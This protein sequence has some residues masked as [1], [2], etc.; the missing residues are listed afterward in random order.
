ML[1][2]FLWRAELSSKS[3][4]GGHQ[5]HWVSLAGSCSAAFWQTWPNHLTGH[6]KQRPKENNHS[7]IKTVSATNRFFK[8]S[9]S[10][11]TTRCTGGSPLRRLSGARRGDTNGF[12]IIGEE[13]I[14]ISTRHLERSGSKFSGYS[15]HS[16]GLSSVRGA[17]VEIPFDDVVEEESS[18]CSLKDRNQVFALWVRLLSNFIVSCPKAARVSSCIAG[19][20]D[21]LPMPAR[22]RKK[23]ILIEYMI[24]IRLLDNDVHLTFA[25]NKTSKS[26]HRHKRQCTCTAHLKATEDRSGWAAWMV[27]HLMWEESLDTRPRSHRE[28]VR[29]ET[30]PS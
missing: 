29:R 10:Y 6:P 13:G 28:H 18:F 11:L 9:L 3:H 15:L 12:F 2:G 22:E 16:C 20:I 26:Y 21:W 7:N 19:C 23:R 8:K 24:S 4:G 27:T 14:C 17:G 1:P 30:L 5:P 25:W